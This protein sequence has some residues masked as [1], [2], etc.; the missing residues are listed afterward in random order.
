MWSATKYSKIW[1]VRSETVFLYLP[2]ITEKYRATIQR[3]FLFVIYSPHCHATVHKFYNYLNTALWNNLPHTKVENKTKQQ[4]R[5]QQT[6][7]GPSPKCCGITNSVTSQETRSLQKKF[8]QTSLR[9]PITFLFRL[10]ILEWTLQ[11]EIFLLVSAPPLPIPQGSSKDACQLTYPPLFS[12]PPAPISSA[13]LVW[14]HVCRYT[15]ESPSAVSAAW[16]TRMKHGRLLKLHINSVALPEESKVFFSGAFF[17][18][19]ST[20]RYICTLYSIIT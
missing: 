18:Q 16:T 7:S 12:F 2:K 1:K 14:E 3:L 19:S 9:V 10:Y 17:S 11:I 15:A 20:I 6:C 13:E 5:S 4:N 8:M